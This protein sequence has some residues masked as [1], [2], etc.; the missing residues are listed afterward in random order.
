MFERFTEKAR[1]AVFF[2]RYEASQFGSPVIDTEH[3][4]LG[5]MREDKTLLHRFIG[6]L[7]FE[8]RFRQEIEKL[9]PRR[10][11]IPTSVEIPLAQ[12]A[13]EILIQAGEE[14]D[15]LAHAYIGTEHLLLGVLRQKNSLGATLLTSLGANPEAIRKK[16][17]EDVNSGIPI[18]RPA[19]AAA[20]LIFRPFLDA[21]REGPAR[22]I[23]GFF[24]EH[25][26]LI[27]ASGKR[28]VGRDQ[29][30]GASEVLFAPFAKK[31]AGYRLEETIDS[32]PGTKVVLVLW[33]FASGSG[34]RSSSMLH[35]SIVLAPTPEA[36]RIVLVQLTPCLPP[37]TPR[38]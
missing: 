20:I 17:A 18:A 36:W 28:W 6:P 31:N 14:A 10:E 33:E 27:D 21:L 15:K 25:S 8:K 12:G 7:D 26:Q 3:M 4:L 23:A 24:D 32:P 22:A 38:I 30:E 35:M 13:R 5:V 19:R 34:E 2:A 9:N 11:R 16:V 29:I 1:R 37:F